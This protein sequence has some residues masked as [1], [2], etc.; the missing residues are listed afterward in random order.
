M[1]SSTMHQSRRP[2]LRRGAEENEDDNE[3]FEALLREQAAFGSGRGGSPAATAF[4]AP[5]R[6]PPPA[7][8]EG[9]SGAAG[10]SEDGPQESVGK[11]RQASLFKQ[12]RQGLA[13]GAGAATLAGR[14]FGAPAA[15]PHPEISAL[16]ELEDDE[17]EENV[18]SERDERERAP[19]R[20][21][22]GEAY[23]T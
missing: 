3:N 23:S 6:R 14:P 17:G 10:A 5:P 4:R 13:A 9:T 21:H 18:N 15:A 12:L 20:V 1:E 16:P 19:P 2:K 8:S 7:E 22:E 11:P